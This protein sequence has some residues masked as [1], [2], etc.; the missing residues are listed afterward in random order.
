MELFIIISVISLAASFIWNICN[1]TTR[2][3]SAFMLMLATMLLFIAINLNNQQYYPSAKSVYE[4]KTTLQIT[5]EDSIPM[6]TVVV[7]KPE[8]R[9]K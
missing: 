3:E 4:G 6:D 5:C 7:F 8:F 2:A 1:K 9:K